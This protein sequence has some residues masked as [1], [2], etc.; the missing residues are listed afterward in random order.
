MTP[1][2]IKKGYQILNIKNIH[3]VNNLFTSY[4]RKKYNVNSIDN[5]RKIKE[6][7]KLNS[8][9]SSLIDNLSEKTFSVLLKELIETGLDKVI[10]RNNHKLQI[11]N[12]STNILIQRYPHIT[13]NVGNNIHSKTL[14]HCDIF[15]GHSPY[16]YTVWVPLHDV[17]TD[18]GIFLMNLKNSLKIIDNFDLKKKQTHEFIELSKKFIN[19]K[20]GQCVIFSAFNFH[21]SE[22]NKYNRSRV[23][24][25][26]RL[27]SA[28]HPI[29][30]RDLFFFKSVKI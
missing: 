8:I 23:A 12:K 6:P 16:T 13:I 20:L 29:L 26:L 25:N 10:F 1:D 5:L 19:I 30:E 22:T 17:E 27:Q 15:A 3:L 11:K 14:A 7:V 18:S 21:G 24:I 2:L 9:K 4:L 28:Y